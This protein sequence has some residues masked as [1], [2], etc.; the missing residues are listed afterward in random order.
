MRVWDTAGIEAQNENFVKLILIG[1]GGEK[2]GDLDDGLLTPVLVVRSRSALI[3]T[4][5]GSRLGPSPSHIWRRKQFR[6]GPHS[7]ISARLYV[8]LPRK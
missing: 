2:M 3:A 5:P 6:Q 8:P 1:D 7:G 4:P